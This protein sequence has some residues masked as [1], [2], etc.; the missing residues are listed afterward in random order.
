MF[1]VVCRYL[2]TDDAALLA[3]DDELLESWC[4]WLRTP[5]AST[6]NGR[7]SPRTQKSYIDAMRSFLNK[8]EERGLMGEGLSKALVHPKQQR[9]APKAIKR[10][11]QEK[12]L[13]IAKE[14]VRD[15]AILRLFF[16][17]GLRISSVYHLN[18]EDVD[19]ESG[20]ISVFL[21]G[22]SEKK[23]KAL[24]ETT[25]IALRAWIQIRNTT[26][27]PLF[28]NFDRA[29][30]VAMVDSKQDASERFR[31]SYTSIYRAVVKIGHDETTLTV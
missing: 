14:D 19:L 22:Y 11:D 30:Q 5:E 27:G 31:L 1:R 12:M 24:P 29:G 9:K 20:K 7:L 17:L 23:Q 21:K 3:L 18:I 2:E 15:Y 16:D 13:T 28:V 6:K 26:R 10:E 4:Y 25:V 8:M